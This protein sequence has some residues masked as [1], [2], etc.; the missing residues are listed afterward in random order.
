MLEFKLEVCE[1]H[2]VETIVILGL[3]A[4]SRIL[5]SVI[6]TTFAVV[7]RKPEKKNQACTGFEPYDLCDTG[8]A[9]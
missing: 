3:S 2:S 1:A 9:L 5:N 7:K 8:A 6:D 4:T